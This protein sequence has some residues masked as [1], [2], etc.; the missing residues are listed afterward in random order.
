MFKFITHN[1]KK[2]I[3]EEKAY[4]KNVVVIRDVIKTF[5]TPAGIFSALRGISFKLE[6]GEFVSVVGKSGSGKSTLINMIT[7]IDHP[8]SGEID[9]CGVGVHRLNE[10]QVA[11]WRG[12]KIGVIFQFFQLLPTLSAVENVLLAMDLNGTYPK[13]ERPQRAMQLL[14]MVEMVDEAHLMASSLSGGQQQRVAIARAM[15]NDPPL[16]VADEPTGNLD[17]KTTETVFSLFENL[18]AAGKTILMVTHDNELASRTTRKIVIADGMLQ[19]DQ[20]QRKKQYLKTG[21]INY[22]GYERKGKLI[23]ENRP[24]A[25]P[26]A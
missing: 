1:N 22:F 26:A 3:I 15:A 13:I 11:I 5:R 9:V 18:A 12:R 23:P 16:L 19:D 17:T 21:K 7:G 6:A 14:E 4:G 25:S 2:N 10:E 24:A 8:T 20:I